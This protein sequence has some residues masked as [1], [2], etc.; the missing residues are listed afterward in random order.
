MYPTDLVII[1]FDYVQSEKSDKL[2]NNLK[3]EFGRPTNRIPSTDIRGNV[4][5]DNTYVSDNPA[6]NHG[7]FVDFDWLA[8]RAIES[9]DGV[10][11][12]VSLARID[13][14]PRSKFVFNRGKRQRL[15]QR[16]EEDL[17]KVRTWIPGKKSGP[18]T[19]LFWARPSSLP[20]TI[21]QRP[22]LSD[23]EIEFMQGVPFQF[24]R[25]FNVSTS[26]GFVIFES[27]H[28][29]FPSEPEKMFGRLLAVE[30]DST[31]FTSGFLQNP[32]L[33]AMELAQTFAPL[34]NLYAIHYW[35]VERGKELDELERDIEQVRT[36]IPSGSAGSSLSAYRSVEKKLYDLQK[37]WP[38]SY[39]NI[40]N[41]GQE[42]TDNIE[43]IDITYSDSSIKYS[44]RTKPGSNRG[45][46]EAYIDS[47]EIKLGE[48]QFD[49]DRIDN[50]LNS[51]SVFFNNQ[52]TN[53]ATNEN[54]NLQKAVKK[55]TDESF[56]LQQKVTE[57]TN[58]SLKLQEQFKKQADENLKLQKVVSRLTAV[59]TILTIVLVFD[60]AMTQ[61]LA[62]FIDNLFMSGLSGISA[63]GW[64]V[65][66]LTIAVG[67]HY[68]LCYKFW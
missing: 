20:N 48:V 15:C 28:L 32:S 35:C 25:G 54:L 7:Y 27:D 37:G 24:I 2:I 42:L 59:V 38:R 39:S 67:W 68:I 60:A 1:R 11:E 43:N 21:R 4:Y 49:A 46:F 65:I 29:L 57:Q 52:V 19:T 8:I 62:T 18:D 64:F 45:I 66:Y 44:P 3:T 55:Q 30:I 50:M 36:N 63:Q 40:V 12:I 26:R 58:E 5:R 17:S 16:W 9:T 31:N 61:G 10:T 6:S 33:A 13:T 34:S 23:V 56:K 53:L 22:T 14:V 47:L 51:V 41:E